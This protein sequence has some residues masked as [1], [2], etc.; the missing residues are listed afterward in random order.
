[1]QLRRGG[2]APLRG[3]NISAPDLC[4]GKGSQVSILVV[5]TEKNERGG[6]DTCTQKIFLQNGGSSIKRRTRLRPPLGGRED[7]PAEQSDCSTWCTMRNGNG[8]KGKGKNANGT[9]V[10]RN[11]KKLA[12]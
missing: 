6:G 5:L 12:R 11:G 7:R 4:E 10:K 3:K 2:E 9:M 8:Q 1:M